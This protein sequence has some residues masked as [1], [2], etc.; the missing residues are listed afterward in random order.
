MVAFL[1]AELLGPE[2]LSQP[3]H[4]EQNPASAVGHEHGQLLNRSFYRVMMIK[5]AKTGY[6]ETKEIIV[7]V[8]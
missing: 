8:D 5:Q 6:L 4:R 2:P 1:L 7:S 3:R